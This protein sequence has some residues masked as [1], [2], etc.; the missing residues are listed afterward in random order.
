MKNPAF[1]KKIY[2]LLEK[3]VI[4]NVVDNS[5]VELMAAKAAYNS[6]IKAGGA[7]RIRSEKHYTYL[8]QRREQYMLTKEQAIDFTSEYAKSDLS[9]EDFCRSKFLTIALLNRTISKAIIES[10]VSDNIVDVLKEKSLK[11]SSTKKVLD[12][13]EKIEYFRNE[14]KKNQG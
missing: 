1:T 10:W 12:F 8:K 11:K 7:G 4:E 6:S 14:N 9:K 2:S 5:I 13:L 3:A